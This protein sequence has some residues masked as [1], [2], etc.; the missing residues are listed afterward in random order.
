VAI[1]GKEQSDRNELANHNLTEAAWK[2]GDGHP[3]LNKNESKN[4]IKMK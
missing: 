2:A 1:L 3:L 4:K